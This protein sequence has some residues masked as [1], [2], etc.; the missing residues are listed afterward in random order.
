MSN[1]LEEEVELHRD[2]F[3]RRDESLRIETAAEAEQFV[4]EVGFS[5]AMT[6]AR[7]LLPSFYIA[8]CGRREAQTPRNVQKDAECSAA[9]ILKDEVLRRGRVYYGKITKAQSIFVT[10][11]L[12]PAFN[13]LFGA[14]RENEQLS[15][16]ARRILNILRKEWESASAD[17]RKE[18]KIADRTEFNKALDELQNKLKVVPCECLYEPK[19]TYIW[20]LAEARFHAELKQKWT[21]EKAL[22]EIARAY[23][24]AAGQAAA[25]DLSKIIGIA[26]LEAN[27]GFLN[28]TAEKF[29]TQ[30]KPGVF[31][32]S[33]LKSRNS[34]FS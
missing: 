27:L 28:L 21:R 23:V 2:R 19:F 8:V 9:W 10:P 32:L 22:T 12:I 11:S 31:R 25:K 18:A 13:A 1:S 4:G 6:D 17:L 15:Q 14:A 20:T 30:I 34:N 3:W 5:A 7:K 24:G 29:T 26:P 16:N 33:V